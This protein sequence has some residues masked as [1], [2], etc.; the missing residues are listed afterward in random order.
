MVSLVVRRHSLSEC[1]SAAAPF[2]AGRGGWRYGSVGGAC[3]SFLNGGAL[4]LGPDRAFFSGAA[5]LPL[6]TLQLRGRG[7]LLADF[8]VEF[9]DYSRAE[10]WR[11]L[12]RA[13]A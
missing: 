8:A 7:F 10:R 3:L 9:S 5:D 12:A 4:Q 13:A 2:A 11:T 6:L 1:L